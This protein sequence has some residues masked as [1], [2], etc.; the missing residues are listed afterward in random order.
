MNAHRLL[1]G[2]WIGATDFREVAEYIDADSDEEREEI[3]AKELGQS[4]AQPLTEVPCMGPGELKVAPKLEDETA[5]ES[6]KASRLTDKPVDSHKTEYFGMS[7]Q[8]KDNTAQPNEALARKFDWVP[9][10]L[11]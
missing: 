9:Q 5:E 6:M 10:L 8:K 2:S 3:D 7:T 1:E 11:I 4:L